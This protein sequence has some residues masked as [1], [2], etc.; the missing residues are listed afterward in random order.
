MT[1]ITEFTIGQNEKERFY[2]VSVVPDHPVAVL[3]TVH[4]MMEHSGRYMEFATWMAEQG[5]AVYL[6]DHRGHGKNLQYI[7]GAR[8]KG[9][10]IHG[11]LGRRNGWGNSVETL[12][13]LTEKIN[14]DHPGLP[15]FILGHSMGSVMVQSYL[16][17]YADRVSG[18]ILSGPTL[19]PK[20]AL[21]AGI[22]LADLLRV[23]YGCQYRS[24]LLKNLSYGSYSKY[25]K[26]RRTDFDWLCTDKAVVDAY[27]RDPMCGFPCTTAFYSDFFRGIRENL[28][29]Y[30]NTE[31]LPLLILAGGKDPTGHFG[32]DPE[33]L[34]NLYRKAGC[35]EVGI[36]IWPEGRHEM[37]NETN[38]PEV[39]EFILSWI[40]AHLR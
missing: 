19:Q 26:P 20:P 23:L 18:A 3:Q 1:R 8:P 11:H 34:G 38:K 28:P 9:E 7:P 2:A 33:A 25:F 10:D 30:I 6:N 35:A 37:L 36:K 31:N 17:R 5:I 27:V 16:R 39:W 24:Y 29:P 32:K 4:G 22:M 21:H 15:V 13:D 14:Q 12:A 40:K